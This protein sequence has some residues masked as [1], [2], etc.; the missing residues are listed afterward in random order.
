MK[1][2][3]RNYGWVGLLVAAFG[4]FTF[5]SCYYDKADLVYPPA[6]PCDTTAVTYSGTVVPILVN[7]CYSC[8][9]GSASASLGLKLDT[10]STLMVQ[11]NN[12]SLLGSVEHQNGFSPMPKGGGKMQD[13]DIAKIRTWIRA[14]ALNN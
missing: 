3:V 5:S 1:S 13:C 14:G 10:Y 9:S 6:G 8:H 7:Q 2:L 12:G 11:V 4:I